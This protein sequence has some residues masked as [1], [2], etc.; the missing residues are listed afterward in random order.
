MYCDVLFKLK[1]A[2]IIFSG[3]VSCGGAFKQRKQKE[4]FSSD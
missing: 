1:S 3:P 4:T 2:Y